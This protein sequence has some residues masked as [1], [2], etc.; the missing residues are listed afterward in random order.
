MNHNYELVSCN[1]YKIILK[2]HILQFRINLSV[3]I[4][5][6][7]DVV[8]TNRY[9]KSDEYE[10]IKP[11][12]LSASLLFIM[13]VSS[14][15]FWDLD[16]PTSSS[17]SLS[18]Y[19]INISEKL[20][21]ISYNRNIHTQGVFQNTIANLRVN[22]SQ[23]ISTHI[24]RIICTILQLKVLSCLAKTLCRTSAAPKTYG[25]DKYHSFFF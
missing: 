2:I 20:K 11:F 1:F 25:R 15:I 4:K 3:R 9:I 21:E 12:M 14:G 8:V 13:L 7:S 19:K 5:Y 18:I 23:Q 17:G 24:H 22:S 16:I 10:K 6:F